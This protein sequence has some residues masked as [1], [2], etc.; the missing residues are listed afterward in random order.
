[1]W[2]VGRGWTC[3]VSSKKEIEGIGVGR[4]GPIEAV[5]SQ[6]QGKPAGAT[7]WEAGAQV[8]VEV[9]QRRRRARA[10]ASLGL[11]RRPLPAFG[12]GRRAVIDR[13]HDTRQAAADACAC[14][15]PSPPRRQPHPSIHRYPSTDQ[16]RR[17]QGTGR[18]R[19]CLP[20]PNPPH[21]RSLA[22]AIR[23]EGANQ[24]QSKGP[25][26][27]QPASHPQQCSSPAAAT[28]PRPPPRGGRR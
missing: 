17:T 19:A 7:D 12:A 22:R 8:E 26:A 16:N 25:S 9:Q 13:S 2:N 1:M 18:G 10:C 3:R 24:E 5:D 11:T 4:S 6:R 20:A 27:S 23:S 14:I 28:P 21:P 15:P